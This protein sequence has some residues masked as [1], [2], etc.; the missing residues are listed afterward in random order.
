MPLDKKEIMKIGFLTIEYPHPKTG[1]SG[2]IGTSILNLAK[3]LLLL[4]H[5]V[6]IIIYGQ[7]KDEIFQE[8]GITFYCIKNIKVKGLSL[9]LTQ[10]KVEKLINTLVQENKIDLIETH[11]WTGFTAFIKPN[12]PVIVRLHG[13][14]TYFCHLENRPVK[15]SNKFLENRAL[16]QAN[17]IISVSNFTAKVTKE[18]FHLNKE[19]AIIPNAIDTNQFEAISEPKNSDAILY[20]GTL[21]R[22]KGLL[23]LPLIF[24]EVIKN[25]PT[26][27]LILVGKDASDIATNSGS[28]WQLMQPL[29]DKNAIQNV[30]Y[31]GTVSYSEIKSII[32]NATLCVFPTFAEALPVSWLEAMA[33]QKPIVAFNIGWATDIVDNEIDG[34]LVDPKNH[35]EFS[36]RILELL[37]DKNLQSQIGSNARKKITTKFSI[38]IVAQ[39]SVD[40]YQKFLNN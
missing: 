19:I 31:F 8:N 7:P 24:N 14:D 37:N 32:Q 27:K 23:E 9:L 28:T 36:N 15:W 33:M 2:G 6:S 39:Q 10:K 22:K 17:G 18:L 34:Y 4:E 13:S 20:F 1:S 5:E 25:R 21:I 16:H 29:F 26:A 40:F 30:T 3:G 38:E 12:C 35:N 11:D